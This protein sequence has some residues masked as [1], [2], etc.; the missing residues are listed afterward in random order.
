[1]IKVHILY[2]ATII[3]VPPRRQNVM[4][5]ADLHSHLYINMFIKIVP[6][7]GPHKSPET[8]CDNKLYT[9]STRYSG[10]HYSL[11]ERIKSIANII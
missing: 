9:V 1:M 10:T 5:R 3:S 8:S 7:T 11:W 2:W 6:E 4:F